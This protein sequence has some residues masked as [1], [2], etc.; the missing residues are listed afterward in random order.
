MN[1][2]ILEQELQSEL[3]PLGYGI[4]KIKLTTGPLPILDILIEKLDGSLISVKDCSKASYHISMHLDMKDEMK[5]KYRLEVSS[6]G[7]ER[8]LVK[9]KDFERFIGRQVTIKL[10]SAMDGSKR[11]NGI[12]SQVDFDENIVYLNNN[13]IK[14]EYDNIKSSNLVFTN[15]MFQAMLNSK[16]QDTK[17]NEE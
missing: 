10:K 6:P 16:E 12:I 7:I 17:D 11:F 9:L 1:T 13:E 15:E 14:I 3:A 2:D 5:T 8:P 4:V